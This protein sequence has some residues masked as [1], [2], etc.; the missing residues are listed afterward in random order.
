V[1]ELVVLELALGLLLGGLGAGSRLVVDAERSPEPED[2]IGEI[3]GN[4][5]LTVVLEIPQ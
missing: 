1:L 3:G 2:V 5:S 4:E